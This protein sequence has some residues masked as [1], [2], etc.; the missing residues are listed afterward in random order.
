MKR[1]VVLGLDG[2]TWKTLDY[3]RKHVEMQNLEKLRNNSAWGTLLSTK[4]PSTIPA[5]ISFITGVDAG[6]HGVF[7]FLQPKGTL[8]NT[9]VVTSADI[10]T[11]TLQ[12]ILRKRGKKSILIN[13]PCG[14]PALTKDITLGSF[15]SRKSERIHPKSLEDELKEYELTADTEFNKG[16]REHIN[17]LMEVMDKRFN[18]AKKLYK[19][20][21][22]FFFVLLS[23]TDQLQHHIYDIIED[24]T[25]GEYKDGI[26]RFYKRVDEI[27]GWFSDNIDEDTV[28]ILMS[29]H[30]FKA[31]HYAF[32]I[33]NFL[34][35][36]GFLKYKKG[37][38]PAMTE[39]NEEIRQK[40]A[41]KPKLNI[42]RI[43]KP[44][45]GH[46]ATR[47][48]IVRAYRIVRSIVPI[49]KYVELEKFEWITPDIDKSSAIS[50]T[51]DSVFINHKKLGGIVDDKEAEELK[52][53]I[54]DL[55]RK[56]RSPLTG[57][58]PF[59]SVET[60]EEAYKGNEIDKAPDI[61]LNYSD[62][63]PMTGHYTQDVYAEQ[64]INT[65]DPYGIFLIHR[66]GVAGEKLNER[67]ILDIAPT[68]LYLMGQ[69]IPSYFDGKPIEVA[70]DLKIE[71][72][73][74]H[75]K[76]DFHNKLNFLKK[77]LN[78]KERV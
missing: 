64:I 35:K 67:S 71:F 27:I 32:S 29:D 25:L 65:H 56:E 40:D 36:H 15:I 3:L 22:D 23:A 9:P 39:T 6:K 8:K 10:K 48:I 24:G 58:S 21:W 57:K 1:V 75:P 74:M 51:R 73:E 30:G 13:L 31:Y 61:I 19:K 62:H 45:Y 4:P 33:N 68:I 76:K 53:K 44:L 70:Q 7:T 12:E 17:R 49:E 37:D 47:K 50:F 5:W 38:M 2:F 26:I 28:L 69:P 60:R 52:K 16:P 20:D 55:L 77:K 66:K 72:I 14:T 54:V 63:N 59:S 34:N 41:K 11:L 18:T 43:I 46:P 78:T 42:K